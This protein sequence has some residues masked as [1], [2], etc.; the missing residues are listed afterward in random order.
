MSSSG[1]RRRGSPAIRDW[2]K[3]LPSTLRGKNTAEPAGKTAQVRSGLPRASLSVA[4][5]KAT[6]TATATQMDHVVPCSETNFMFAEVTLKYEGTIQQAG[7]PS[8]SR[9]IMTD[10]IPICV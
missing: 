4:I 2:K 5:A 6:A 3:L 10:G 8:P 9:G 7:K 1:T